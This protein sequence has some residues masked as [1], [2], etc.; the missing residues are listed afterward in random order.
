MLKITVETE[1]IDAK[2]GVSAKTG[3]PYSI[4]EQE[5]WMFGMGRDGKPQPHPQKIK[6]T[7]D[8]DQ[9]GPYSL[10]T[11][12]LDPASLYVDRFGQIAI[13]ARLRAVAAAAPAQPV[14]A[15]A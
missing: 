8:D 1:I 2:N 5:A 12:T 15:A 13:R 11:Y 3:K 4:R 10:G 14:R 6:L 9:K 7:L